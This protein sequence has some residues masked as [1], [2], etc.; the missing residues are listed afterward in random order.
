[1]CLTVILTNEI[2]LIY[3]VTIYLS[4]LFAYADHYKLSHPGLKWAV[5]FDVSVNV[6]L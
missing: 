6:P 1:M 5:N 3:N 2:S 4:N